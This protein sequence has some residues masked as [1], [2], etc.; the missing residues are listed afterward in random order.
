MNIRLIIFDID[1][2][3]VDTTELFLQAYEYVMHEHKLPKKSKEELKQI[4]SVSKTLMESYQT[5]APLKNFEDLVAAHNEFRKKNIHLAKLFP[6]T[7][8]T[9]NKLKEKG[10]KAAGLT[11]RV[12]LVQEV[13]V[14]VKLNGI[15]D[16]VLTAADAGF[17]KPHPAGILKIMT[18]LNIAPENTMMV[19]DTEVD[20]LAGKAAGVAATV[21]VTT[22]FA[23]EMIKQTEADYIIS[24]LSELLNI[25]ETD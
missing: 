6:H 4:V 7:L 15:L 21:G 9:L 2:T 10:I 8:S 24:D 16:P 1:G 14:Q 22:G 13:L 19:G 5:I 12:S 20:V 25:V 11:N 18:Q 3:L 23:P 17:H